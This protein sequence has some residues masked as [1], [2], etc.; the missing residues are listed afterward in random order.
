MRTKPAEGAGRQM[1]RAEQMC[2][3][4]KSSGEP[5]CPGRAASASTAKQAEQL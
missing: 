4:S 1:T 3:N 5:G 2:N